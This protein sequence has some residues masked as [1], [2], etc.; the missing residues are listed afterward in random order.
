MLLTCVQTPFDTDLARF[1]ATRVEALQKLAV[2]DDGLL[3]FLHTCL[4]ARDRLQALL[5]H[6]QPDSDAIAAAAKGMSDKV[7]KTN[8]SSAL[9]AAFMEKYLKISESIPAAPTGPSVRRSSDLL[10]G[11]A[12]FIFDAIYR[13]KRLVF[14]EQ[15]CRG[16]LLSTRCGAELPP[17]IANDFNAS[18]GELLVLLPTP[19]SESNKPTRVVCNRHGEVGEL[20]QDL[21][22]TPIQE[23]RCKSHTPFASF[24]CFLIIHTDGDF[25]PKIDRPAPPSPAS[26]ND[27]KAGE[28]RRRH[29]SWR[30]SV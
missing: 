29:S 1:V 12:M 7:G 21:R 17:S 6:L 23:H 2:K 14:T 10:T 15:L 8:E 24:E 5:S 4:P 11:D 30:P 13:D 16:S 3:S 25:A 18:R 9:L 19:K 27:K 22:L 26:E 28:K 20:L